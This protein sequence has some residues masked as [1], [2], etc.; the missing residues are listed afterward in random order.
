MCCKNLICCL[1]LLLC[2][3]N[4][5]PDKKTAVKTPVEDLPPNTTV[6]SDSY[7]LTERGVETLELEKGTSGSPCDTLALSPVNQCVDSQSNNVLIPVVDAEMERQEQAATKTQAVFRGYL[8]R[9]AFR[10][11]KGIIRLQALIRGHLVR[12]QAVATL[13]CMHAIVKF[14]A[15][16][17]GRKVRLSDATPQV[18]KKYNVGEL[19]DAKRVN[20]GANS[21]LRLDKLSTNTFVRKLLVKLPTAMPLSLQYDPAEPN[22]AWSWL[23]RWSVSHFWDPPTRTK[24]IIKAKP[25]RKQGGAQIVEP[26]S[27]KSRR[28]IRKVSNGENGASASSEMDKPKRNPRKLTSNQT[29]LAQ[30]QQAQNELERVKRNLRK[31]SASAVQVPEKSETET[32]KPL[33]SVEIAKNSAPPDVPELEIAVSSEKHSDPDDVVE[34]PDFLETPSKNE[35]VD[36]NNP[37]V[38]TQSF[39]N[40]VK[41]E[42]AVS[43]DDE[44]SCKEE[45]SGKE[46]QKVR[47]RRSLPAKQEY[48]EKSHRIPQ[49]CR[50][51]WRPLN[52]LRPSLELKDLLNLVKMG[53]NMVMHVDILYQPLPMEN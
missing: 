33:Q 51:I 40:G 16:A 23:E 12:R 19:L 8:A 20:I 3:K 7:Q 31:V 26:E 25:Q 35:P 24:K 36:D 6:I 4:V 48:T 1:Q 21:F 49:A 52:L 5:T 18:R 10:A 46:N 42:S 45:K 14:Q 39:E 9:R 28:T 37:V 13:R 53:P 30:E 15:L 17:R 41:I 38:E 22:S 50:V 2:M 29:E 11:L 43:L 44:L 47:K 32:E 34:N 27:G